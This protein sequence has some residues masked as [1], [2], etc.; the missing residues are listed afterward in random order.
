MNRLL[1]ECQRNAS[2]TAARELRH[3]LRNTLCAAVPQQQTQH[4]IEL[5][6]SEAVNNLVE[7]AE[8]AA[9]WIRIR[10]GRDHR[11]WWL[12][13]VDNSGH[14]N[15]GSTHQITPP[16]EFQSSETGRGL[17]LLH[18]QCDQLAYTTEEE[19]QSNCLRLAWHIPDFNL[20]SRLLIV[21]DDQTQCRLYAAY[22]ADQFETLIAKDGQQALQ[23]LHDN[24]VDLVLS[25]INM[26]NMDG[27]A[28]RKTLEDQQTAA[29]TPF[30]F[31]TGMQDGQLFERASRMG[32]DDYLSKPVKK[33]TLIR[34]IERVLHR[35]QQ[36]QRNLCDRLDQRITNTLLPNLPTET[37]HWRIAIAHRHT[38][39][40]GGDF[41]L[42][43]DKPQSLTLVLADIMGHNDSAKFFSHAF[44]GYLR[45]LIQ[46]DS[47]R[48][49]PGQLLEMLSAS[50][51]Q[52]KLFSQITLSCCA[53]RLHQQGRLSLASAAHPAPLRI[54]SNG[55]DSLEVGGVLPGLLPATTYT[56]FTLT[57]KPGERLALYTDGLFD[58]SSTVAGRTTLET[59]IKQQLHATLAQP[60]ELAMKQTMATFDQLSSRPLKD[61]ALLLLIESIVR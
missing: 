58:C 50:A 40:G 32:I 20:K 60:I 31:L 27:I 15:P 18:T 6:L 42:H 3:E 51:W 39:E 28:L 25:D 53:L 34:T 54:G 24:P 33:E 36:L 13:I 4:K 29:I 30:I 44:A 52:D 17:V 2:A 7:H 5:L 37:A 10:F 48:Q 21:D 22:L 14:W 23:L 49:G 11:C 59:G 8:P 45:G 47:H 61:D 38:G 43:D 12:E 1:F 41:L 57:L 16:D 46:A 35:S 9:D 55:I 26:P 19:K 56:P